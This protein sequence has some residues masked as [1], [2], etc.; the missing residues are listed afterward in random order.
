MIGIDLKQNY[1]K[2]SI[3]GLGGN[4]VQASELVRKTTSKFFCVL[5]I[6]FLALKSQITH[7]FLHEL[8]G[9][10]KVIELPKM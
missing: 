7:I 6:Q 8:L 9:E 1:N 10:V 2:E 3:I 4:Q 5:Y